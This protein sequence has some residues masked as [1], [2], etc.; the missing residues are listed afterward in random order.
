[1]KKYTIKQYEPTDYTKWNAFVNEAKNATFLFH[2]DFMEYHKERFLD[3]SLIVLDNEKWVAILPANKVEN[4]IY[5]HQG[6]SYGGLLYS[7]KEKLTSLLEI[8]KAVLCFLNENGIKSAQIK[9]MPSI[10][11][12]K[13]A[14]ELHYILF[15]VNATLFRRDSLAVIN[16]SKNQTVS[17]IRKR[18]VSLGIKNSLT[19]KEVEVFDEFWNEILV[20][21]LTHKYNLKPVHS[22]LEISKLKSFFPKNIRQFNVYNQ[23]EIVAGTTVF[24][25]KNVAHCQY[26]SVKGNQKEIGAL[27]FLYHHL[28]NNVFKHKLFFDFGNSN[29]NSGR[30]LNAG[31][32]Y[33]KE[34]F[35]ASTVVHDYYEVNTANFS[36]LENTLIKY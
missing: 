27:D 36:L 30:N 24:E 12:S 10:Y 1:M 20:P 5:S 31:L 13:P 29:E 2:R 25:S 6:L 28:I 33:W 34:S 22:V 7:E 16:L 32:S 26:I 4:T 9:M 23:D 18:G 8:F 14:D 21:N 19:I 15:L 35:G 11:H 17:N 3:Y